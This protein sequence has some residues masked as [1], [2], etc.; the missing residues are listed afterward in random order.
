MKTEPSIRK[1]EEKFGFTMDLLG[2][3]VLNNNQAVLTYLELILATPGLGP[4]ARKYAAKAA[5]HIRASTGLIVDMK[6]L[7]S[8]R[9]AKPESFKAADLAKA[10]DCAIREL[11]KYFP[12]KKV[13]VRL[14]SDVKSAY[15]AGN[16]VA[17]NLIL[18]LLVS[19]ARLN[20]T[21]KIDVSMALSKK[22]VE[23]R[24]YWCIR[25]EDPNAE[26]PRILK[27]ETIEGVYRHDTSRAAKLA[28]VLFASIV[29]EALGGE[30]EA[31]EL[32]PHSRRP[33]AYLKVCLRKVGRP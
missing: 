29:S 27:T 23:G 33:G 7:A 5:S 30:L 14:T 13:N 1:R 15:A 8:T 9:S 26:L 32:K 16:K 25:F 31:G 28:E 17:E 11:P 24:A 12:E 6:T 22:M 2:H 18:N 19:I 21:E 4:E 20:P 10:M 3:D